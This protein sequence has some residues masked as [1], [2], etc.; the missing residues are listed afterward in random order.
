MEPTLQSRA[1]KPTKGFLYALAAGGVYAIACSSLLN[2][3]PAWW[4]LALVCGVGAFCSPLVWGWIRAMWLIVLE[5]RPDHDLEDQRTQAAVNQILALR[6]EP[7]D[8]PLPRDERVR[9]VFFC[10]SLFWLFASRGL[11]TGTALWALWRWSSG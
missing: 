8:E 1:M 11:L 2:A 5:A 10:L 7:A 6:G 9:L 4:E 3:A